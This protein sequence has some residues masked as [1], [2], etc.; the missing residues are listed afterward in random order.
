MVE[1][2]SNPFSDAINKVIDERERLHAEDRA[3]RLQEHINAKREAEKKAKAEAKAKQEA[4]AKLA[5]ELAEARKVLIEDV[6]Q[7]IAQIP[8]RALDEDGS[9]PFVSEALAWFY[10]DDNTLKFFPMTDSIGRSIIE[11]DGRLLREGS[12]AHHQA[13][14]ISLMW[15]NYNDLDLHVVCPSGERIHGGNRKSD[16]GGELDVDANVRPQT[17]APVEN[18]FWEE[19]KAPA[20]TYQVYVHHYKKHQ[21]RRSKD[22][23]RF[24]VIIQTPSALEVFNG[25][26]S[27]GDPVLQV[28]EFELHELSE[29]TPPDEYRVLRNGGAFSELEEMVNPIMR[30]LAE[31]H[32]SLITEDGIE[33][34]L[35]WK[36]R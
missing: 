24:E 13:L 23:T 3:R 5:L 9:I 33:F 19:G 10:T 15:N 28:H 16:C 8:P 31:E 12:E 11:R 27:E 17:R 30:W 7:A 36:K 2:Q 22:P 26:I 32:F 21:K 14:Q 29:R 18:V 6:S 1:D 35:A 20:G 25:A 34:S 4:K